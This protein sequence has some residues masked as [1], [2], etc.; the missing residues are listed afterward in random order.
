[1][2]GCVWSF[3]RVCVL[4]GESSKRLATPRNTKDKKHLQS[5]QSAQPTNLTVWVSPAPS[6]LVGPNLNMLLHL[7][8]LPWSSAF[9]YPFFLVAACMQPCVRSPLLQYIPTSGEASPDFNSQAS[10]T[11]PHC[12][13]IQHAYAALHGEL[14]YTAKPQVA[15]S[16]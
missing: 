1:M 14:L 10:L 13:M 12:A 9:E 11:F 7:H 5:T 16:M 4:H 3:V 2:P 8:H 15:S 6:C